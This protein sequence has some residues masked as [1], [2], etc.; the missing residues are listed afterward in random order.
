M[1]PLRA[2]ALLLVLNSCDTGITAA[3]C[4]HRLTVCSNTEFVGPLRVVIQS[5]HN[6]EIWVV[7]VVG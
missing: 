3:I 1:S 7:V 5:L 6:E 2:L 4:H